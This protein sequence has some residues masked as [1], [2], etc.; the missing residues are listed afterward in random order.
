[1]KGQKTLLIASL[2]LLAAAILS[3][4]SS[5]GSTGSVSLKV[6]MT[7]FKFDPNQFSVPAGSQVKITATNNGTLEH[8]F[9]IMKLGTQASMTFSDQDK[10]N[11]LFQMVLQ[12]GQTQSQTFTAPDQPGDYEV[13]CSTPGHLAA[14]M[15]A[16][17]TVTK[18]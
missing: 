5:G 1:M 7:E 11:S 3:A 13:V 4:C 12:P 18:P 10:A 17:L 2:I 14:G 15:T 16:K 9:V 8:S 6:T